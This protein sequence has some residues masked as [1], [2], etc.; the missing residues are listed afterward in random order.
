MGT[1]TKQQLA[2]INYGINILKPRPLLSGSQWAEGNYKLS[3]ES[4][5][6]PGK[7]KLRPYQKEILDEMTNFTTHT[8]VVKKP[9]RVGYT[10]LLNITQA[11]FIVQRPCSILH[12]QPNDDEIWGYAEDEFEPMIRDN[13]SVSELIDTAPVRGR[14][15]KEKTVKKMYPGG[16]WE[17]VG[18]ESDKNFNRRTVKV[19]IGDEIDAWK[20]EA[21]NAG[22]TMQTFFRRSSD[23]WDR[24][25]IIGGKPIGRAYDPEAED[26]DGKGVSRVD[27]WY[28]LGDQ[29]QR[30][31]P[32]PH[33]GTFQVFHFEDLLWDKDKNASG[34]TIKH[35]PDTAHF[36]CKECD[37]KIFDKDKRDMDKKGKWIAQKPF[38]GIASFDFWAM[39]SYSPNV[40]WPDIVAEFLNAKRSRLKLKA[41][42]NEV[43]A[44]TWEEDYEK[45]EVGSL[46][47]RKEEYTAQ[48]PEGVLI[49]TFG[50]DTQDDRIE[51]EVIGWGKDEESWSIDYKIF[52][53]DTS[54][55]EV[56]KVFDQYLL[57]T[58]MHE[59][60]GL[61]RVFCGG[62][63]T[64]G[65]RAKEAYAFCKPR[66]SRR[67]YAFKGS[68]T[69]DAPL[70]PRVASRKNKANIPLYS[71]GVN[72]AKDVIY[73]HVM[74]PEF[75]AG[76]MH[77]PNE[78]I[79]SSE[80]FKQLTAEQRARDGRW[81]KTRAR[82]E[83]LDVRVYGYIA[84]FIAGID[85]EVMASHGPRF[86]KQG[87]KTGK[88]TR[89]GGWANGWK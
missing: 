38:N 81:H 46:E 25:N 77:F 29:R 20:A 47:T 18:A 32:C 53:G 2:I 28:K 70:A 24:K 9:T 6:A 63:D 10:K 75:G 74:T 85:L 5:S 78:A 40:T 86:V 16:I 35:H 88:V 51:C 48:V 82:N 49:L 44:K 3:A 26:D 33:C 37:K 21:G 66:F 45:V 14:I 43:L 4:S 76:Y 60:G 73:S 19:C 59:S 11:Y 84:L 23:F 65:H 61:M 13:K 89:Q 12:A 69:I 39:F 36:R 50:A 22:D 62:L 1:M 17:G 64:Q 71:V 42:Y 79:Y 67:V 31:L 56:W 72:A 68:K 52:H 34:K 15:K 8:V 87:K 57:K 30:H 7:I 58:W 55:P 54:K 41:F 80:Y 27:Y 83:A